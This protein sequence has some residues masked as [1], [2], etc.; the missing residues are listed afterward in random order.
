[1][2]PEQNLR[3]Y[4]YMSLL[5][6]GITGGFGLGTMVYYEPEME[7]PQRV[8][9]EREFEIQQNMRERADWLTRHLPCDRRP[10][11]CIT[12][13]VEVVYRAYLSEAVVNVDRANTLLH[14]LWTKSHEC[15]SG[16]PGDYRRGFIIWGD[17]CNYMSRQYANGNWEACPGYV[18]PESPPQVS[19]PHDV[20]EVEKEHQTEFV[21]QYGRYLDRPVELVY[22]QRRHK[23]TLRVLVSDDSSLADDKD[24]L[25]YLKREVERIATSPSDTFSLPGAAFRYTS[26]YPIW[27]PHELR[28]GGKRYKCLEFGLDAAFDG[29]GVLRAQ[30]WPIRPKGYYPYNLP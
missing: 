17:I 20:V 23:V 30:G 14:D 6:I 28:S 5:L 12:D 22:D 27:A 16:Y 4:K 2:S 18:P 29:Y 3:L 11:V 10:T 25:D 19:P 26:G 9:E 24:T 8:R 7:A 13:P 15:Y 21:Y 1:M